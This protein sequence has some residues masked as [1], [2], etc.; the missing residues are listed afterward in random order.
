MRT[1]STVHPFAE[2]AIHAKDL[3][4]FRKAV[5]INPRVG[6][7]AG[8]KASSQN[9]FPPGSA[10][11]ADV[12][13][14]QKRLF[15]FPATRT[16]EAAIGHKDSVFDPLPSGQFRLPIFGENCLFVVPIVSTRLLSIARFA[17]AAVQFPMAAIEPY[18]I[19]TS[20]PAVLI[21]FRTR[22]CLA[23]PIACFQVFRRGCRGQSDIRCR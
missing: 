17:V 1:D 23:A 6:R 21:E 5:L 7:I 12:I 8:A 2:I 20:S 22:L 10:V 9:S 11:I 15:C 3:E 18:G 14:R 19:G 4:T 13:Q 16:P